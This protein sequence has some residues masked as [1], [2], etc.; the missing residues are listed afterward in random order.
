MEDAMNTR[1]YKSKTMNR[2]MNQDQ[3]RKLS[4]DECAAVVGGRMKL[5]FQHIAIGNLLTTPDG[6]PI[7]VYVDGVRINSVT[8]GFVHL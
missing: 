4:K 1:P 8:T 6:D 5:P 7:T 2:R 3:L